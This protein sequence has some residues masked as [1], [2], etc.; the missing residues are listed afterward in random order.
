MNSEINARINEAEVCRSM[1]LFSDSLTIYEQI[2]T[3]VPDSD[4]QTLEQIK[5]RITILRQEL[6]NQ[7]KS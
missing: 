3:D 7:D 4:T 6:S 2:L 1:G 5:K